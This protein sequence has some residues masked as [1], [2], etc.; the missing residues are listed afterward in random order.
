MKPRRGFPHGFGVVFLTTLT[1]IHGFEAR[2]R[3]R[4]KS[5]LAACFK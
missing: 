3:L 2:L 1:K 4:N 5:S